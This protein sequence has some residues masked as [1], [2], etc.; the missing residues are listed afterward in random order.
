M[1]GA[2]YDLA[3]IGG[4]INGCGIARDAVGR[5]LSVLLC[6]QG[7]LGGATSSASTK[8]IHGGLRYLEF[9]EFRLVHE[10]LAER[11]VLLSSAP[12]IVWPLRFVLPH[13]RGLRPWP[14]IRLGLF[15]YDHLGGRRLLPPTR[16]VDLATDE[17]WRR[18]KR[19]YRRAYE[20]SECWVDDARLVV[21]NA[22]DAADRGADV[23][24]HTKCVSARR[25]RDGWRLVLRDQR[26]GGDFPIQARC[27]VNAAGPWV[28]QVLS[29][30]AGLNAPARV[31]LV[32]G[33]HIVVDRVFDHDRAYIF[34]NADGRICFAI[35]YEHDYTLIGTT[36]EDF[37]GD[38]A[39]AAIT[40][41]ETDYLLAAV[42]EYLERPLTR[43]MIRW[44]YAGVRPL[45]DDGAS[46]AQ[47]ATRDYVLSL[48]APNGQPALL[49]VFGGKITTYRRL[50]EQALAKLKTFFPTM[51]A[52]WTRDAK[53]PGGDVPVRDFE[54]WVVSTQR[55]YPFLEAALVRR[56]CRAYGSR[57]GHLLDGVTTASSLGHDFGA[58]LT[59]RELDY[60]SANEW[61]ETADDVL[62]RRSKLGLRVGPEVAGAVQAYLDN[63][64][65]KPLAA[66]AGGVA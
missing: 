18:L 16:S 14:I 61:A 7:D 40:D 13:H 1:T 5:G 12:H 37:T 17:T 45:Y 35:P 27:L 57:I 66:S 59:G 54:N 38:P 22:R 3:I 23:R 21:L 20:Y 29:D 42:S 50:A 8:L 2:A 39:T 24:T 43:S 28:S 49:S 31:R 47:E 41:S 33:S 62:W 52:P 19:I 44:T 65:A 48:D 25:E 26:E 64:K 51:R 11:E 58:G 36:D 32:K 4:G 56:L 46:K 15:F 55:R 6:E 10:A 63:L 9:Y 53:L 60:L 34:Q 30:V